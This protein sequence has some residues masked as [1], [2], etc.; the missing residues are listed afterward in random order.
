MGVQTAEGEL[1]ADVSRLM[2][3]GNENEKLLTEAQ[4]ATQEADMASYHII[5]EE[6]DRNYKI[7]ER[8]AGAM[9]KEDTSMLASVLPKEGVAAAKKVM[10]RIF[11]S[12][13]SDAKVLNT[14]EE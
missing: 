6:N 13:M 9:K 14:M 11:Q 7:Q 5:E 8:K 2:P 1:D 3:L 10:E 12:K 4:K